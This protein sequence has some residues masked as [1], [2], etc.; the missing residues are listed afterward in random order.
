MDNQIFNLLETLGIV[1]E[2]SVETLC[3][4]V[5]DRD[6]VSVLRCARSGVIFLSRTDHIDIEH[7]KTENYLDEN[8]Q[9]HGEIL[10]PTVL[11]DSVRRVELFGAEIRGK[12]WLDFGT[13][14]AGVLDILGPAS[15][16]CVGVE[17]NIGF[18][19]EA[20]KRGH[21]VVA[22]IDELD[23]HDKFDVITLFHVFEHLPA[24]AK[25][26]MHLDRYLADSGTIILE[27]PHA[28]DILIETLDCEA[29][30]KFTFWSEHLILH[31][32][33]SLDAFIRCAGYADIRIEG[34]QRYSLSNHL[35]WLRHGA[36]GGHTEWE[37]LNSPALSA[38]YEELLRSLGQTD[39][40]VA[41]IRK[42][43]GPRS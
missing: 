6:D 31:T 2:S 22:S 9:V 21:K 14:P 33:E 41:R 30:K 26:L 39:T 27:V 25:L 23:E 20:V 4:R 11:D 34:V 29:F 42:F 36:P 18:R 5:R 15:A 12:R 40:L 37:F 16:G 32:R 19:R 1:D 8:V 35:Y 38:A 28:H 3:P 7:Y 10:C 13:G 24:P 17:P 43:D